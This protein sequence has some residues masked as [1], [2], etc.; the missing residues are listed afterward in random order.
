MVYEV[1]VVNRGESFHDCW[2][3]IGTLIVSCHSLRAV[4]GYL[5][6]HLRNVP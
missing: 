6:L 3:N 5:W 1:A 4:V 2:A